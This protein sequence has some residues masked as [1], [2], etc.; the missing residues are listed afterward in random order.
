MH[1]EEKGI[2]NGGLFS[3]TLEGALGR[4]NR[5][6]INSFR[7][8]TFECV[9]IFAGDADRT[10]QDRDLLAAMLRGTKTLVGKTPSTT[11][12]YGVCTRSLAVSRVH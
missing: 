8:E 1:M 11:S 9:E 2:R 6:L 5:S 3:G 4:N 7:H 12:R 10:G